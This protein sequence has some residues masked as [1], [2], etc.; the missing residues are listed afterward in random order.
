VL[1]VDAADRL[2]LFR[3]IDDPSKPEGS[4]CWLTPGGGVEPGERLAETAARELAEEI[5]LVVDA[6]ALGD[7]VAYTSGYA[8]LGWA[9]TTFR[10]DFFFH[11]V[12]AHDV[13]TSGLQALE[14]STTTG[15]RWWT[16]P[17]LAATT[18]L[19]YPLGLV[20]LLTDLLAGRRPDRPV[21]LPWHH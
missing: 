12:T 11:R 18:E 13:D 7:P 4:Y 9:A 14:R 16:V 20:P 15:H 5:G 3:C 8:D 1:L 17:E 6:A 10:D 2:L 19:V 21:E